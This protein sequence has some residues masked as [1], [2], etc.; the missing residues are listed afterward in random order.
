MTGLIKS[1]D[2]STGYGFIPPPIG[3]PG[4][5][6][7]LFFNIASFVTR[8]GEQIGAP[9][10]GAEVSFVVVRGAKGPQ[11]ANCTLITCGPKRKSQE[12]VADIPA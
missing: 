5:T 6:K 3:K 11:A 1:Y 2:R 7:D 4:E 10:R 9:P 12:D 8:K